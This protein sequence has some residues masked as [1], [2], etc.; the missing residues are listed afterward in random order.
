MSQ[1]E[2]QREHQVECE[3]QADAQFESQA[4]PSSLEQ[5]W[6]PI[7]HLS[8]HH[9]TPTHQFVFTV[10]EYDHP[11]IVV[12]I[13][14]CLVE[15]VLLNTILS[16]SFTSDEMIYAIKLTNLRMHADDDVSTFVFDV[17]TLLDTGIADRCLRGHVKAACERED[18]TEFQ[19]FTEL[20]RN[21][22]LPVDQDLPCSI[23]GSSSINSG[24]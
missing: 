21:F 7:V 9:V 6:A 16:V 24:V 17:F 20:K 14:R 11:I 10:H 15:R 23:G 3:P 12:D 8:R 1:S 4:N 13:Y 5:R 2:P 18:L 22:V 19:W